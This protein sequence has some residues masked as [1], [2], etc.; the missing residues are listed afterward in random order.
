MSALAGPLSSSIGKKAVMAVT[1]VVLFGF[2]V[3][4]LLGNLQIFIPDHGAKL[5]AYAEFLHHNVGPLWI[6]R[7]ILLGAVFLHI[8]TAV[9]LW[10]DNRAA[11]PIPYGHKAWRKASYSSRTMMVSG[12]II[13]LFVLYHLSHLTWGATHPS[14][15]PLDVYHNVVAG[16]SSTPAALA[17]IAAMLLLGSHLAHGLWSM[18]QTVGLNHPRYTP[19]LRALSVLVGWGLALGNISIPLAVMAGVIRS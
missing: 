16:F 4:H 10:L 11:R 7:L 9:A 15:Q 17:Y 14:F 18:C 3:G 1:G 8:G 12:P 2:V 5:N 6:A 13:A 19:W